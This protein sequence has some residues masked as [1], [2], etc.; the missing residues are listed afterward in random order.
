MTTE[1]SHEGADCELLRCGAVRLRDRIPRHEDRELS[2]VLQ[3]VAVTVRISSNVRST[4][5]RWI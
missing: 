1:L 2:V 4:G 5:L 3:T